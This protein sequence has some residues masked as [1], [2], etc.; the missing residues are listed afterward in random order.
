MPH[1]SLDHP[2]FLQR[3]ISNLCTVDKLIWY[4]FTSFYITNPQ[5]SL[6]IAGVIPSADRNRSSHGNCRGC[7]F[8]GRKFAIFYEK[9]EIEFVLETCKFILK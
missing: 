9:C 2:K 3:W 7:V 6:A 1:V 5:F 4:K 8:F